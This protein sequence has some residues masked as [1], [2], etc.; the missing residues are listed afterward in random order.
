VASLIM[1]GPSAPDSPVRQTM[2]LLV[3]LLL[4]V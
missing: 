3:S 2:T 1:Y 4:C